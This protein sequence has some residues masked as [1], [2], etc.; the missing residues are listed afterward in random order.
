MKKI[1]TAAEV[2]ELLYTAKLED[3]SH[4]EEKMTKIKY[5]KAV[6]QNLDKSFLTA[7]IKLLAFEGKKITAKRV[8]KICK[9]TLMN[10]IE[11]TDR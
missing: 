11:E 5:L 6:K 1:K 10:M 8:Q 9:K 3:F 2:P 7:A 4:F